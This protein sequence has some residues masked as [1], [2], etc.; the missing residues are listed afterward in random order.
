MDHKKMAREIADHFI[1]E[2]PVKMMNFSQQYEVLTQERLSF[3][4][5]DI[6]KLSID[7]LQELLSNLEKT[8]LL[9]DEFIPYQEA[10]V[11]IFGKG[12]EF[13]E[14]LCFMRKQLKDI[15]SLLHTNNEG[16]A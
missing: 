7:E 2:Y 16:D 8:L 13:L 5:K 15:R 10:V 6:T 14:E 4:T 11:R 1:N 12:N 9:L 3:M